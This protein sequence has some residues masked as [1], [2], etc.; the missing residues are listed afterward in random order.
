MNSKNRIQK[1]DETLVAQIAAGE[2]IESPA[3][4]VKEL[5]ENAIDAD[6]TELD[7]QIRGDGFEEI[8][9][10]DNGQGIHPD[11]LPL[12]VQSFATSKIRSLDEL[13]ATSTMGF[14][15]EALGSIASVT[16]LKIESRFRGAAHAMA[17]EVSERGQESF[18]VALV[19]GTRVV[20]RDLFYNV[21][22]RREYFK[23]Q[24]KV[25][26]QL[27]DTLTSLAVA[28]PEIGFRYSLGD[29]NP[30]DLPK[31]ETLLARIQDIWG[32][33]IENHLLPIFHEAE[34]IT[35]EGYI[36]KFYFYK[37][38]ASEIRF[39][40]N[41]RTV[42]YRP[43]TMLLRHAYGEL[44]QVGKFPFASLFLKIDP[45][46]ID[47]NVHPQKREIRFK[48]ELA[49]QQFLRNA[50][51]RTISAEGG[52]AASSMVRTQKTARTQSTD[53]VD[54]LEKALPHEQDAKP[55]T[56]PLSF[57]ENSESK[58]EAIPENLVLHSHIFNTFVL[59]TN[60]EGVY[61]F[62]QHTVHERIN[63]ENF[64][65]LLKQKE[66]HS[67]RLAVP[68]PVGNTPWEKSSILAQEKQWAALGFELE[69]LGP[70]GLSL[71]SVPIYVEPGEE[72]R[73]FQT[74]LTLIEKTEW[75]SDAALFDQ[76]AKDLSCCHAIRKGEN[77]SLQ[78]FSE[79]LGRLRRC[80]E[81]MRCPH[82]RPTLVKLNRD[83]VFALFKRQA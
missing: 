50:F 36:S 15:G 37:S 39:W 6:A 27:T 54:G 41:R 52:I 59:A 75:V 33:D 82:G 38:H 19:E 46:A 49:V 18:P 66:A 40:V 79:L 17:I 7:I 71:R 56:M 47:I 14:R 31:R 53:T 10:R 64:L 1:L 58:P 11:D 80:A 28:Y 2:V 35:L 12:A 72:S 60:D 69:D 26:R 42:S 73:A 13:M 81:P 83:E 76:W 9:V 23:N 63:Y 32:S 8:Q 61:L 34:G 25:R 43:L 55:F 3:A 68:V 29:E 4:I 21:P 22:V 77:T 48:E 24:S 5:I 45:R 44:M 74:A 67:Q 78:N 65:S 57:T 20:V 30:T 51:H 16:R 62:D 70:A